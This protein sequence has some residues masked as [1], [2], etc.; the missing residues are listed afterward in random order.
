MTLEDIY[1]KYSLE[2]VLCTYNY[3]L[4]KKEYISYKNYPKIPSLIAI[5]MS[6][7]LPLIFDRFKYMGCYF[8]DGGIVDNFPLCLAKDNEKTLAIKLADSRDNYDDKKF[9]ILEYIFDIIC[10]HV[11]E[12]NKD[13]ILKVKSN[14]DIINIEIKDMIC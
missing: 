8:I 1:N 3:S 12:Y 6:C 7:N 11:E 2:L 5:R 4:R 13:E 10:I 9:D 14:C